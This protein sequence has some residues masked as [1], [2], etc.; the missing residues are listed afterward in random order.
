VSNHTPDAVLCSDKYADGHVDAGGTTHAGHEGG[1]NV[2]RSDGSV[3]FVAV[4]DP[5]I[6][7]DELP[8]DLTR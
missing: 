7:E 3:S 2:L 6:G 1:F 8:R 4:S 5:L